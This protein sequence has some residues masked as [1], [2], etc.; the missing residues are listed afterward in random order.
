VENFN[1]NAK[2]YLLSSTCREIA[3]NICQEI[4]HVE[5]GFRDRMTAFS[6]ANSKMNTAERSVKSNLMMRDLSDIVKESHLPAQGSELFTTV[7]AVV[8]TFAIRDWERDYPTGFGCQLVYNP[9]NKEEPYKVKPTQKKVEKLGVKA[10]A[11]DEHHDDAEFTAALTGPNGYLLNAIIPDSSV[12]IHS[13]TEFALFTVTLFRCCV[14]DFSNRAREARYTIR[15]FA[16]PAPGARAGQAL[17][18]N[19]KTERDEKKQELITFCKECFKDCF[20]AWIHLKALRTFVQS[21]LRYGLPPNFQAILIAPHAAGDN[22]KLR[23]AL[24]ELFGSRAI[25]DDD[26][27]SSSTAAITFSSAKLYPYVYT[28]LDLAMH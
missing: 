22:L 10:T 11:A 25:A 21:I 19:L 24:Q 13:D 8:P 3:N 17:V 20:I 15:E 6:E 16:P 14:K 28:E 12:M 7:I 4:E 18:D 27:G 9:D 1:W 5:E 23:S 26:P 2:K